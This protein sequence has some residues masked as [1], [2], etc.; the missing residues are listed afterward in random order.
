LGY[1]AGQLPEA[2]RASEE[3]LSL[4]VYPELTASQRDTVIDA[5]RE[6]AA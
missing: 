6:F 1:R 4:P 3:V 2:E 5:V